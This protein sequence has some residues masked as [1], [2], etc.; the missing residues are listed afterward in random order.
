ML[1]E[2]VETIIIRAQQDFDVVGGLNPIQIQIV[3]DTVLNI[4]RKYKNVAFKI[5]PLGLLFPASIANDTSHIFVTT[6]KI[7]GAKKAI[8]NYKIYDI[9]ANNDTEKINKWE[10][11]KVN[12]YG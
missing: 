12:Q 6:T 11:I 8:L 7:N 1:S 9:L 2:P 4:L 10:D 5:T 3:D